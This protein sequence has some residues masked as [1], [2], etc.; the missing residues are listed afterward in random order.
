MPISCT[1]FDGV[2][3][4]NI[5]YISSTYRYNAHHHSLWHEACDIPSQAP[6]DRRSREIRAVQ[7]PEG[8]SNGFW[9]DFTTASVAGQRG[10]DARRGGSAPARPPRPT[11]PS[12]SSMSGRAT[13]TATTRPTP[14]GAAALKKMPGLKVVEEEKVPETDAVE[15]TMESHD[16]S[17]RRHA[18]LPDLVR[19]LQPA[20]A[21][22]GEQVSRSCTSSTAAACG[23]TRTRRTPAAISAIS[24]RPSTSPASS[25]AMTTKSGKL[26]FVAAKPIPQVL[27]N[28]NAFTLG[29]RSPTRRRPRR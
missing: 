14:Q 17:R 29:A 24:T 12:A 21:Q 2:A 15:K 9:Q 22:D 5:Q 1:K 13:T 7:P 27:R 8:A 10:A 28:I 23:A 19:L 4:H 20:H 11:P 3:I 6:P 25:P 26:G 16:Q 18:A